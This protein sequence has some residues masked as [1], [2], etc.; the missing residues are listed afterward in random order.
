MYVC[1]SIGTYM[2]THAVEYCSALI[3][4]NLGMYNNMDEPGEHDAK[5]N[6]PDTEKQIQYGLTHTR[7]LQKSHL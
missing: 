2:Y 1:L 6:K 5:W 7:N 3:K 4:R